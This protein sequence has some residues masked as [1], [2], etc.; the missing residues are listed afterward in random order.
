MSCLQYMGCIIYLSFLNGYNPIIC[1]WIFSES[2]DKIQN[3]VEEKFQDIININKSCFRARVQPCKSEH[4]WILV[5]TVPIKQGHK[6]RIVWPVTPEI[7]HYIE[8]PCK[9]LG[10]LIDH[11]GKGSLYYILKKNGWK[12]I[13]FA[14]WATG[15]NVGESDWSLDFS[16]FK[17]VI[18]LNDASHEHV[19]DIIGLL[20]KY[21]ELP[22]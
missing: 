15:L 14:G 6:L 11:E 12:K 4:L 13:I 17:V 16:F 3:L 8:G 22:Q 10:H 5:K 2:L 20:F 7:H 1:A 19:Q 18:D 21:I 9:Y